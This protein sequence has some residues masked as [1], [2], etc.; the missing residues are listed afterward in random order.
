[1]VFLS[2]VVRSPASIDFFVFHLPHWLTLAHHTTHN[3]TYSFSPQD[4]TLIILALVQCQW[5]Q[6][7]Q[8]HFLSKR[9]HC[10]TPNTL[11]EAAAA[12]ISDADRLHCLRVQQQ[13]SFC[14]WPF[15]STHC[16]KILHVSL[17]SSI[18]PKSRGK[19]SL[20]R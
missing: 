6:Q 2:N 17:L 3:N 10:R 19:S 9:A 15:C 12:Y 16:C 7:Q 20:V 8:Q 5:Q 11:F 4:R 13:C 14:S 1:M 18:L